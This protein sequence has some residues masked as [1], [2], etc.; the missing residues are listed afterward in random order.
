MRL[1]VLPSPPRGRYTSSVHPGWPNGDPDHDL[2]LPGGTLAPAAARRAVAP[3]L[4]GHLEDERL[5]D[6]M[7]LVSEVVTNAVRH[8]GAGETDRVGLSVGVDDRYVR[9][10]VRDPGPGFEPPEVPMPRP[11]GGGMGLMLL[12]AIT[13]GYGVVVEPEDGTA[14]WFDL[15]RA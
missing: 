2:D 14:V 12:H 8:G 7:L 3:L 6:A 4:A 15:P 13:D 11:G 5:D 1:P 9:F 10:E